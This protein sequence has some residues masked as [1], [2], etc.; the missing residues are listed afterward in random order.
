MVVQDIQE[1]LDRFFADGFSMDCLCKATN[2]SADL[3]EKAR[4]GENLIMDECMALKPVLYFLT[5]L[6]VCDISNKA[7]LEDVSAA[8]CGYYE[9]SLAAVS[10][11]LGLDEAQF[12]AFLNDPEQYSNGYSLTVKLLH[13]FTTL[14]RDKN[15]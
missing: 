3:I 11:Y 8:I 12:K 15:M 10:N 9:M 2:V 7:Y 14:V 1:L 5:Q 13:L 4:S 6:Y